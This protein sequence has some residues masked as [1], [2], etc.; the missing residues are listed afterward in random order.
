MTAFALGPLL[1][2]LFGVFLTAAGFFPEAL[3][4]RRLIQDALRP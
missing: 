3:K 1:M 2:C 4:A